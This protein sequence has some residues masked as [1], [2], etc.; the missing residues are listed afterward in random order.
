MDATNKTNHTRRLSI[1]NNIFQRG[2][3]F[4]DWAEQQ[5]ILRRWLLLVIP[6][7][8]IVLWNLPYVLSWDMVAN[9]PGDSDYFFQAYEA[10][11]K[12]IVEY[13]QFPWV[14]IWVGGGVP[15][16][17]NP[18][19]GVFSL[20]TVL[21]M[22]FGTVAGLKIS[23]IMYSLIGYA[24][25]FLLF[26]RVFRTTYFVALLLG[27]C[28]VFN[29]FYVAHLFD[30]YSFVFFLIFPLA[31]YLQLNILKKRVWLY[32]GIL[33]AL[34]ALSAMHYAFLQ[35]ALVL[36][37]VA[38]YQLITQVKDREKLKTYV[39]KFLGVAG[40]FGLIAGVRV[41]YTIQYVLE[42]PKTYTE[43]V[44]AFSTLLFGLLT[45]G[46][47]ANIVKGSFLTGNT[48]GITEYSAY[49][50]LALACIIIGIIAVGIYTQFMNIRAARKAIITRRGLVIL[51]LFFLLLLTILLAKGNF[52]SWSPAGILHAL[53]GYSNMRVPS[54]ALLWTGFVALCIIAYYFRHSAAKMKTVIVLMLLVGTFELFAL[55]FWYA[56]HQ[57]TREP[58]IF[59][60]DTAAFVEYQE[61]QPGIRSHDA[62]YKV[63]PVSLQI[64]EPYYAYEATRNNIGELYGY[65]PV[66]PTQTDTQGRCGVNYGC[67]LVQSKN[68]TII[69]WSPNKIVLSRKDSNPVILNIAPS[70][71]WVIN[72]KRQHPTSLV[73]ESG[74]LTIVN[75]SKNITITAQ[76]KSLIDIL[77]KE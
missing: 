65:E 50:G 13:H 43:P 55:G 37:F 58:A 67:E 11:R 25:A 23:I 61:Y 8:L 42:F 21:A 56:R 12:S 75:P 57:F 24:G 64:F 14:N 20:Q 49:M 2:K 53:P 6:S 39:V 74:Q 4:C 72:G 47:N 15:L 62:L 40:V 3:A 26:N 29:G 46:A 31:L 10:I 70:N 18:Q 45:P 34:L 63:Q 76:P 41:V 77:R 73:V 32:Y 35:M 17:A 51:G 52:D 59:R 16:F 1:F 36:F 5:L 27:L 71:Y 38:V 68:A 28:W 69:K 22:I 44:N 48:Y 9:R 60:S 30:H 54:R 19:V 66:Y 33:L 7:L